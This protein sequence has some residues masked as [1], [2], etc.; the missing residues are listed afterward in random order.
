MNR[1]MVG[2]T[3]LFTLF[4]LGIAGE[5]VVSEKSNPTAKSTKK[6]K[7]IS[8]RTIQKWPAKLDTAVHI[9]SVDPKTVRPLD[10]GKKLQEPYGGIKV[11]IEML[12]LELLNNVNN[13]S[14]V[15][16]IR[17]RL[18]ELYSQLPSKQSMINTVRSP[19]LPLSGKQSTGAKADAPTT[20]SMS[21]GSV[22]EQ[23]QPVP[24]TQKPVWPEGPIGDEIGNL[25]KRLWKTSEDGG[26]T[27]EIEA[28]LFELW[29]T[30]EFEGPIPL[31]PQPLRRHMESDVI[32]VPDI[33][34]TDPLKDELHALLTERKETE[35]ADGDVTEIDRQLEELRALR[36][37]T[38]SLDE[39][40]DNCS[41]PFPLTVPSVNFGNTS[42]FTDDYDYACPY[43]GSTSPDVVYRYTP[44]ASEQLTFGLCRSDYDTKLFIYEDVCS[45]APIACN[46]DASPCPGSLGSYRSLLECVTLS[47]GHT[48][49]IVVDGYGGASGDYILEVGKC[50]TCDVASCGDVEECEEVPDTSHAMND[51]NG[52]C[53]TAIQFG[54]PVSC[55]DTIE[56]GESFFGELFTYV[57][58][59]IPERDIDA[60]V[61]TLDSQTMVNFI[62]STEART[63]F[64]IIDPISCVN[65]LE[66]TWGF[67]SC[68][69]G[70][71]SYCLD[72]GT[73]A[74][75]LHPID[76]S[77]IPVPLDYRITMNCSP[78]PQGATCEDPIPI[79]D[80]TQLVNQTTCGLGSDHIG[81]CLGFSYEISED[82]VY[83]W[84]VTEEGDYSI[85]LSPYETIYTGI[86]LEDN[87]PP[88][89]F[90][91]CIAISTSDDPV[92]HGF[93]CLHLMPGTYFIYIDLWMPC[94]DTYDLG[95]A[96]CLTCADP[97]PGDIVECEEIPDSSHARLD[98]NGGCNND[99][100]GGVNS[101]TIIEPGWLYAGQ[102]FTYI[103]PSGSSYRDTDWYRFTLSQT[104]MIQITAVAEFPLLFGY[105]EHNCT[106]PSFID[107]KTAD[108][109]STATLISS[110]L[111][112]GNYDVFI[113]PSAFSG[114][115]V[116]S[117]YRFTFN[118]VGKT[119]DHPIEIEGL[120]SL[121]NQTTC[122]MVNDYENTCLGVYDGGEDVI[123]RWTVTQEN[124]Y[125]I[126]LDPLG[127]SWTGIVLDDHCPPDASDCIAFSASFS[128]THE[129]RCLNLTPGTYYIMV[130]TWPSPNCIPAFDLTIELGDPPPVNSS[131][132]AAEPLAVPGSIQGTTL[133][134]PYANVP[135]C[136]DPVTSRG[137]WY[138]VMGTGNTLTA[139]TCNAY[140][141]FDTRLS[142]YACG[143]AELICVDGNDDDAAC[144]YTT[145]LSTVSWCSAPGQEYLILVHGCGDYE[146]DF[147]LEISD[148]GTP[149]SGS[150]CCLDIDAILPAPGLVAGP[151]GGAGNDC[152]LQPSEDALVEV[153]IPA[154]GYWNFSLCGSNFDTYLS[155]GTYCCVDNVCSNDDYLDCELSP[156][157]SQC[158]CLNLVAGIYYVTIEG[159]GG[160]SGTYVLDV[161]PGTAPPAVS[162][163]VAED[164]G[165]G[166]VEIVWDDLS[167][168]NGY[169]VLRNGISIGQ[170]PMNDTTYVD[171]TAAPGTY[172]YNVY[173]FNNCGNG[174]L[175]VPNN[176][177]LYAVL[178][179]V[180]GVA[181]TTD[182][183][184]TVRITWS[185]ALNEIGYRVYRDGVQI[186][187]DL[188]ANT[189]F[190]EDLTANPWQ[191]YSYDVR[192]L[193]GPCEGEPSTQV[194]GESNA[195]PG[196]A[197]VVEATDGDCEITIVWGSIGEDIDTYY[198]RI[199]RDGLWMANAP[200]D[201]HQWID[202]T[203]AAST[204]YAYTVSTA[205]ACGEGP[206][207]QPN[208]GFRDA[209]P[210][211]PTSLTA[212]DTL[213]AGIQLS[214]TDNSMNE[215]GFIINMPFSDPVTVAA[216]ETSYLDMSATPGQISGYSV[217]AFNECGVSGLSNEVDGFRL[218]ETVQVT[219]LV[220]EDEQ[221]CDYV[222][223]DWDTAIHADGYYINRDTA[224]LDSVDA[225]FE[226][227]H[228]S[229]A[230]PGMV[231]TYSVAAYNRC[232][233]ATAS[234]PDDG[235]LLVAPVAVTNLTASTADCDQVDLSWDGL[236]GVNFY[237]IYRDLNFVTTVPGGQSTFTDS[238]NPGTYTYH[239][240]G[241]N[242]CGEGTW[243]EAVAGT[244][245]DIPGAVNLTRIDTAC[246]SIHLEWS[247]HAE[248][249][250][251]QV[252]VD[253]IAQLRTADTTG[254]FGFDDTDPHAFA[255]LAFNV[256]GA[257]PLSESVSSA[258]L[259]PPNAPVIQS[260]SNDHCDHV[261]V[262]WND[263]SNDEDGFRIVR[264]DGQSDTASADMETFLDEN[265]VP[266]TDYDYTVTAF[267]ECG[268]SAMSGP[269]SGMRRDVPEQ[270]QNLTVDIEC[271]VATINWNDVA[272]E[273]EYEIVLDEVSLTTLPADCT[274][275]VT[276]IA[277]P[278][279]HEFY[280]MA[281]NECGDGEPSEPVFGD[282][283]PALEQVQ[284][285]TA[286]ID[287]CE[288]INLLWD[289]VAGAE[290][291][292][293][294]R[295]DAEMP[296]DS[297]GAGEEEYEDSPSPGV[298]TY[299]V[300]A[301][302]ICGFGPESDPA[303]GVRRDVPEPVSDCTA[304]DTSCTAIYLT[305]T[306]VTEELGYIVY[307]DGS[308]T[309]IDSLP[310]D[311]DAYAD[312]EATPGDHFYAVY[313][314][315]DCGEGSMTG[316]LA[317]GLRRNVPGAVQNF[318]TPENNC[319]DITLTWDNLE[320]EDGYYLYSGDPPTL[321]AT[322]GANVTSFVDTPLPGTYQYSI[323]GFNGC[324][325]GPSDDTIITIL[326]DVPGQVGNVTAS[327]DRCEEVLVSWNTAAGDVDGYEIFDET[328]SLGTV[329]AEVTTFMV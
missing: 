201:T 128:G 297:T 72:S 23:I 64:R 143:C 217:Y 71:F 28:R 328:G 293:L 91:N 11:E 210:F 136:P 74:I 241:V 254:A 278:G 247:S 234:E 132:E 111:A 27:K 150:I 229:T 2:L 95:I 3:I 120:V 93:N 147:Q 252:S 180:Q 84:T 121:T 198:H 69:T 126:T 290:A 123:Y 250:S 4:L 286:S 209:A 240:S 157:Q 213:C 270:V 113:A 52:G 294:Y 316:E 81:Y 43:T 248:A 279:T 12:E 9:Y 109:C 161:N 164:E 138:S 60:I 106:A 170:T 202:E 282:V 124:T 39:P 178:P 167:D 75:E 320:D 92:P 89:G 194:A 118:T 220:A 237:K 96:R 226:Y 243:S 200:Q 151:T 171:V 299:T 70:E 80:E 61:F 58:E 205:T 246:D 63:N 48:Y 227:Y 231:H 268:E 208:N 46:D 187:S 141:N 17:E 101:F 311:A 68:S 56:C 7:S 214:W 98:C 242:S 97:E 182:L 195:I 35:I 313:P 276:G 140:T 271:A 275:L 188:P 8:D 298:H 197:V 53:S 301:R 83:E 25:L 54:C 212:S 288:H 160:A 307:R 34:E 44:S 315:N 323:T 153:T 265:A 219:G 296:F 20:S 139:T 305:W 262:V 59:G 162:N 245:R 319:T 186:G 302:D 284:N 30:H 306:D 325:E 190:C 166:Q 215:Q 169:A 42:T 102:G 94:I 225:A 31:P 19:R 269:L 224:L 149:C 277:A 310:A 16:R 79:T 57:R 232:G 155:I 261:E 148:D 135:A 204:V 88:D 82:I 133:C 309:P 189:V 36:P 216:N 179:V 196:S 235:S 185:D 127:T 233:T 272:D 222:R 18:I 175:G 324:G 206:Q 191:S 176:G 104:E 287:D 21:P 172:N 32:S 317:T 108:L 266:G 292:L 259:S 258:L 228:D 327:N 239:V 37:R 47:T 329:S 321:I 221:D 1:M 314:Y 168:E 144:P 308:W 223:L 107:F 6:N 115:P 100:A 174:S 289:A 62:I 156:L 86:A 130:D 110:Q 236:A 22:P 274:S 158:S 192:A 99:D 76:Y 253:G 177:T 38:I 218:E 129:L 51:C 67:G 13:E 263:Q 119:C 117:D 281:R 238:P 184:D 193:N 255:V 181:A 77:G 326:V 283:D 15:L 152:D 40:G 322:L 24:A 125:R 78:C 257:G 312:S 29:R 134:A 26:E 49:Y 87:C 145:L 165:C 173:A 199:Y 244:R 50:P 33:S 146:G 14:D 318:T 55:V 291:Y 66:L 65:I 207:S 264:N 103:G 105:L 122:G 295:D 203:A 45:G 112:P 304:S 211:T 273:T 41:D 230:V 85:L 260:A 10:T 154:G 249:D 5:K 116:L 256:C 142:V 131:C 285:L 114:Y 163:I 159:S 73:Y 267:N 251:Y 303:E 90:G 183:C 300:A 280:I 137:V